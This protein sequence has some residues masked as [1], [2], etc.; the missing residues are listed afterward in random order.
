M[1]KILFGVSGIGNGHANRETPIIEELAKENRIMIFAHDDSLTVL[2]D[3]FGDNKNV[4]LVTSD[5][6]SKFLFG[7]FPVTLGG[8][9]YEDEVK[10]L[11][12]FFPK[13]DKR[14]ACSFFRVAP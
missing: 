14:I 10:R 2:T 11:S 4:P 3:R 9:T 7:D 5:Q 13:A 6:Q 12:M 1:K 8:F